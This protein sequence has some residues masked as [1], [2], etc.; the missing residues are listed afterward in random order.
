MDQ[1]KRRCM[2]CRA[3]GPESRGSAQDFHR[4]F[5]LCSRPCA[6]DIDRLIQ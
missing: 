4:F 5:T 6:F 3:M 2:P 1:L